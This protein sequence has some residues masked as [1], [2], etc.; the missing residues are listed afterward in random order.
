MVY[1]TDNKEIKE[2]IEEIEKKKVIPHKTRNI[3]E[4]I[5]YDK[6]VIEKEICENLDENSDSDDS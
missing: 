3:L 1:I 5:E 6:E 4:D 2:C